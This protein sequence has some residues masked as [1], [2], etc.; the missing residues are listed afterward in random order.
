MGSYRCPGQVERN[1][2]AE[3]HRCP[4]CGYQVEIFSDELRARCPQCGKQVYG[5][6]IPYCLDWCGAAEECIGQ[7]IWNRI[8]GK[9][10]KEN[11]V[12][13]RGDR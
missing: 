6:K 12:Q 13:E 1:L 5:K 8:K 3:L 10:S 7:D 2:K 11:V 9:K 4:G